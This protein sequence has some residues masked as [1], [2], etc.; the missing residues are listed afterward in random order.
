MDD[1]LL[2]IWRGANDEFFGGRLTPPADVD[3][4]PLTEGEDSLE[5][6]GLYLPQVPSIAIDERFRFDPEQVGQGDLRENAK[7]EVACGLMI[8]EMV[9][10]A[11]HQDRS[12]G[13]GGHGPSFIEIA[14]AVAASMGTPPPTE[15]DARR[16]PNIAPWVAAFDL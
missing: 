4:H 12:P 1:D 16:W 3:W 7:M 13:A 11:Q 6:F 10:Q 2:S 8:H 5:A 14:T 15:A 9:H